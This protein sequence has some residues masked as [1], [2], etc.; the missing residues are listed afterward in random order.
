MEFVRIGRPTF[1]AVQGA[2][3]LFE[4]WESVCDELHPRVTFFFWAH[5]FHFVVT[6]SLRYLLPSSLYRPVLMDDGSGQHQRR[7]SREKVPSVK[8]REAESDTGRN[9]ALRRPTAQASL[10][11]RGVRAGKLTRRPNVNM[12]DRVAR[13]M[14]QKQMHMLGRA[15][16]RAKTRRKLSKV[17][18]IPSLECA[19]GHTGS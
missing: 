15:L 18:K 5:F 4:S 7:S 1:F 10:V 3:D 9:S 6:S 8:R 13:A 2:N 14:W 12:V 19:I 17:C 11:A 16:S